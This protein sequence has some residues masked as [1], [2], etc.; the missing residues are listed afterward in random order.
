MLM[1]YTLSL[2]SSLK[3]NKFSMNKFNKLFTIKNI[4][5]INSNRLAIA[6]MGFP[7]KQ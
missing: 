4:V 1:Y 5:F 2:S 7:Q 6:Y 3:T